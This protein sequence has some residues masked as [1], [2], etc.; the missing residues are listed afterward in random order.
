MEPIAIVGMACRLPQA[1]TPEQFW[2][3][4]AQGRDAITEVPPERWDAGALYDPDPQA[5]GK[6]TTRWG[7]IFASG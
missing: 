5:M 6:A 3:L 7:G 1:D 2:Q 4:M